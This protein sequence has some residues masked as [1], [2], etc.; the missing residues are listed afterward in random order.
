[1]RLFRSRPASIRV[2]LVLCVAL[3]LVSAAA[4]AP[5]YRGLYSFSGTDGSGPQGHLD[6]DQTGNLYGPLG[7][8]AELI[9]KPHGWKFKMLYPFCK[10]KNCQDGDPPPSG[11]SWD[12]VGNL[13]GTTE[14]GGKGMGGDYGTAFQ[15]EHLPDGSWKH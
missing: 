9:H 10:Q 2:W 8:A 5:K 6:L 11:L 1:M 14:I 15:L 7:G 3:L 12:A 4:A 13:Y